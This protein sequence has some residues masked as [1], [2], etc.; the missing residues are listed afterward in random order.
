MLGLFLSGAK[1]IPK[2]VGNNE[3][4]PTAPAPSAQP[5]GSTTGTDTN[6]EISAD[7]HI[8]G[9]FNAPITIVEFSDFQCPFCSRFHPTLLK[10]LDEY[11]GKVRWVYKHF[12]LASIHPQAQAAAE[13]S[14]CAADQGGN[15]AFWAYG[16][17]LFDNQSSLGRD[18]YVRL[19]KE[20]GLN[21]NE[22]E[23]CIDSGKFKQKV[24]DDYQEGIAAGVRGTP[25]SFVNGQSI[26][27]AVPYEQVKSIVDNLL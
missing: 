17:A 18:L 14:E 20:Q 6:F 8:R 13:A 22:F 11:P 23:S 1:N 24:Q 9:D 2:I 7:D 3:A 15:D 12:P 26:P 21:T 27:G 16:D 25:G 10:I 4:I 19:A 5:A